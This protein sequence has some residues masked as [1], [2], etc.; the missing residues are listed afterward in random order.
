VAQIQ[1]I[2]VFSHSARASSGFS[3]LKESY[4]LLKASGIGGSDDP[5]VLSPAHALEIPLDRTL[6]ENPLDAS[7]ILDDPKFTKLRQLADTEK[8]D[9]NIIRA[10]APRARLLVADMDST[11]ITSESLDEMAKLAKVDDRVIPITQRSMNGEIDFEQ[12]LRER[13]RLLNGQS[14]DIITQT[15]S[16]SMLTSGAKTLIATMRTCADAWC[17]LVSGGFTHI[18]DDIEKQVGFNIHHAN[19]LEIKNDT[20]T[21]ELVGKIIDRPAK[22]EL[23]RHYC[24]HH[25]LGIGESIAVGDGAND[26]DMLGAAGLGVAFHARL[27]N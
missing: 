1:H 15:A 8:L 26:L 13:V 25:D 22:L 4:E 20:L 19:K 17:A 27:P 9:V 16:N 21:G 23:L 3:L 11:I 10:D 12:A 24:E 5:R 7:S 2:A 14:T 18:C 6:G